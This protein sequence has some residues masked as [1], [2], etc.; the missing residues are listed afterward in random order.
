MPTP[1]DEIRELIHAHAP[2]QMQASWVAEWMLKN[3]FQPA[4]AKAAASSLVSGVP[5]Q[6]LSDAVWNRYQQMQAG[7]DV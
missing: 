4:E 1:E 3:G 2:P 6:Q 7:S 5:R